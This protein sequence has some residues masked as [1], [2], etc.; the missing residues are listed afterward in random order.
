MPFQ[1][2]YMGLGLFLILAGLFNLLFAKIASVYFLVLFLSYIY[3]AHKLSKNVIDHL[4]YIVIFFVRTLAWG[5][6]I[7]IGIFR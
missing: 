7:L 6:G 2:G 5:F 4:Y 3:Q 1:I